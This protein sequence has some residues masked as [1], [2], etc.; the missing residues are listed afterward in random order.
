MEI[1]MF[2]PTAARVERSR[3]GRNALKL[4]TK[5]LKHRVKLRRKAL[6]HRVKLRRKVL[7]LRVKALKPSN[8]QP[9]PL[10]RLLWRLTS[11]SPTR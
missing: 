5:A 10:Q 4:Q 2:L 7:R 11:A 1:K 8:Q 6:K 9:K 3:V